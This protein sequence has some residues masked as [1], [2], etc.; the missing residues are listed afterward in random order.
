MEPCTRESVSTVLRKDVKKGLREFLAF[1]GPATANFSF[2]SMLLVNQLQQMVTLF[3]VCIYV[4]D[5]FATAGLI[6]CRP[7]GIEAVRPVLK[8]SLSTYMHVHVDL[9]AHLFQRTPRL[10]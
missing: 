2:Q 4:T 7:A 3:G 8:L 5:Q 6:L 10:A 9:Y 1:N